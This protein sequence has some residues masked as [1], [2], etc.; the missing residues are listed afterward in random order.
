[1]GRTIFADAARAWLTGSM[2]DEQAVT[3]MADRFRALAET[4]DRARQDAPRQEGQA[5]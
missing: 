1:V 4:W 5:A 3:Q 2:T